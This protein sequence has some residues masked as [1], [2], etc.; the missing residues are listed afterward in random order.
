[1][2]SI[3]VCAFSACHGLVEVS[4]PDSVVAEDDAFHGS[5]L[6]QVTVPLL[7][8]RRA[9]ARTA[10]SLF[11]CGLKTDRREMHSVLQ[12]KKLRAFGIAPFLTTVPQRRFGTADE[13]VTFLTSLRTEGARV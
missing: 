3:G 2:T 9:G 8:D 5:S 1:V 12:S 4:L 11:L 7:K 10:Q 13:A 6:T